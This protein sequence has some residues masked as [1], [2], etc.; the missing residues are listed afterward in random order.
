MKRNDKEETK[1]EGNRKVRVIWE[2]LSRRTG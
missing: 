1:F 2:E